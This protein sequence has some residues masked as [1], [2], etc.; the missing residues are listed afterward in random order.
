MP[1]NEIKNLKAKVIG[2]CLDSKGKPAQMVCVSL[3]VCVS[4]PPLPVDK[5]SEDADEQEVAREARDAA[6]KAQRASLAERAVAAAYAELNPAPQPA[7][8]PARAS[9]KKRGA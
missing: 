4:T 7:P 5:F 8:K 2:K 9:L 1:D 6:R 3:N